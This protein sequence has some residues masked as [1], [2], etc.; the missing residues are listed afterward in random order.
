[1]ADT[2][3]PLDSDNPFYERST[4]IENVP[5]IFNVRWSDFEQAWYFDLW[6]E[7]SNPI[8]SGIKLV[9]GVILARRCVDPRKPT[10]AL[11]LSDLSGDDLDAGRF[12]LGTRVKLYYRPLADLVSA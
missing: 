9:L 3:L 10:G 4:T 1:M 8:V 6:D 12:D 2:E 7:N 5:Y 11:F